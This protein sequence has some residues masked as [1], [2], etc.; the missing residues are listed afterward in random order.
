L[1]LLCVYDIRLTLRFCLYC[2]TQL[3]EDEAHDLAKVMMSRK[4]SRLYGRMKNGIAQKKAK[5]EV[6]HKRRKELEKPKDRGGKTVL[7]LQVER[8]KEERKDVEQT[9]S[10]AVGLMK[11]AKKQKKKQS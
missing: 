1:W 6:L 9:Y 10:K 5:V 7:K 3:K 2:A 11:K 4:A 8:L